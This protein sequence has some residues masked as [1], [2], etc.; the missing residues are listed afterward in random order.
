M[1]AARCHLS[2]TTVHSLRNTTEYIIDGFIVATSKSS[3]YFA[4]RGGTVY[5]A[6][7]MST[8]DYQ[9]E[10]ANYAIVGE[11]EWIVQHID[12]FEIDTE[13]KAVVM[14][15]YAKSA[16]I[17]LTLWQLHDGSW[18]PHNQ[19]IVDFFFSILS[20]IQQLVSLALC[21]SDIKPSNCLLEGG[22]LFKLA[23]LGAAV[24]Y[25]QPI[26]EY[27]LP[28]CLIQEHGYRDGKPPHFAFGGLNMD[29][30][31][32]ATSLY[33]LTTGKLPEKTFKKF[34]N[35]L[36]RHCEDFGSKLA[37]FCIESIGGTEVPEEVVKQLWQKC[38]VFVKSQVDVKLNPVFEK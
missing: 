16:D 25:G 1:S 17:F 7:I 30:L 21:H 6:K 23:D 20:A 28:Y 31:C 22:G 2:S 3:L 4:L 13:H 12:S 24:P 33:H 34:S 8:A 32:L 11:S 18:K 10:S 19:A 29:L 5:C 36:D 26:V 37:K 9:K 14:P 38:S 35:H 27:T 15:Y